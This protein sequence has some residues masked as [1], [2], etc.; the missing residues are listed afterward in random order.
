M[1]DYDII[2]EA[3]IKANPDKSWIKEVV[4]IDGDMVQ[5][6]LADVLLA[7]EFRKCPQIYYVADTGRFYQDEY[8]APTRLPAAW[9]LRNDDLSKQSLETLKFLAELLK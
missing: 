1:T 7:I 2:R 8:D 9:N 3:C 6:T 4:D 5:P